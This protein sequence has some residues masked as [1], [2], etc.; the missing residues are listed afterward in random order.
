M[1]RI[2][3]NHHYLTNNSIETTAS[4]SI[5][6]IE[7]AQTNSNSS[8]PDQGPIP[9]EVDA[10]ID[11]KMY[12]RKFKKLIRD[13]HLGSLVKL[14][15]VAQTKPQP[16]RWFATVTAKANWERT[17]RFL[18][19]LIEIEEKAARVVAKISTASVRFVYQQIWR[20]VNV[21]RW[22]DTAA[23]VRHDRPGHSKV[24]HFIWLCQREHAQKVQLG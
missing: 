7:L 4:K 17:L 24:K 15:E 13:G 1:E 9:N 14:A 16:S 20:G 2:S 6:S 12:R 5:K 8:G 11:N 19:K 21:E 3:F 10:L 18:A 23:E 22:A